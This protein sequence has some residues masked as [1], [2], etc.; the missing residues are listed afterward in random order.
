MNNSNRPPLPKDIIRSLY[1]EDPLLA[2]ERIE[3]FLSNRLAEVTPDEKFT[4]LQSLAG[5]FRQTAKNQLVPNNDPAF[6]RI[7]ALLLGAKADEV[8]L[9]SPQVFEKLAESIN[10]VFD[11]IN[12]IILGINGT[13]AGP[14][15]ETETIR[16]V[17]SSQIDLDGGGETLLSYLNQIKEAFA[18][19][20]QAF[21][22]STQTKLTELL[23]EISPKNIE[24][25]S[26]DSKLQIGPF[27]KAELFE[28]YQRK[29][30]SLEKLLHSGKLQ[31]KFIREFEQS[32][33]ELY[34]RKEKNT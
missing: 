11:A 31:E 10:V 12:D 2:E 7:A 34:L 22:K 9:S 15:S 4:L 20:L 29:F 24:E 14:E 21:Q 33:Q 13:F 1:A 6:A 8:D 17:I 5:E 18:M 27:R 19:S 26:G 16:L 30:S 28:T 23:Y 25:L 32:C 3:E